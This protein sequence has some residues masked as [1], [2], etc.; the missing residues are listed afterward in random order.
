MGLDRQPNGYTEADA[1]ALRVG[2]P[3]M[4]FEQ[5]PD[6]KF[7]DVRCL[8]CGDRSRLFRTAHNDVDTTFEKQHLF[9]CPK[10]MDYVAIGYAKLAARERHD[11]WAKKTAPRRGV[12]EEE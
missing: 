6:V 3:E 12:S 8:I 1:R 4:Y 10:V 2:F 7:H 9:T 5:L 11:A